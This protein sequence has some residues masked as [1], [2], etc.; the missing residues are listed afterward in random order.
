MPLAVIVIG[1]GATGLMAARELS[2]AG[3]EVTILE[4]AAQPGGRM[5]TILQ[6]GFT[7]PVEGGAEF[8][9][10]ELE[11]SLRL[12]KE[13]GIPLHPVRS[14]MTQVR[15]G[16]WT[17]NDT[18]TEGWDRL[19]K[20]MAAL[21]E[22]EPIARFL[23]TE[24]PEEKYTGLRNSVRGF[25]EGYDLADMDRA[26]TKALYK[27]WSHEGDD[28]EYRLEGGYRQLTSYLTGQ[29]LAGGCVLHL[30]TPVTHIHWQQGRVELTAATG[31]RFTG[32][33]LLITVPLGVLQ[34]EL[35]SSA[36][37]SPPGHP[38]G[39]S[40]PALQFFPPIPAHLQA[41]RQLGYGSVIKILLE[42][43]APFWNKKKKPGRTLFLLSDEKIPTWWTQA[44]DTG[45]LLTGWL[46]GENMRIFQGQ[47]TEQRMDACLSAVASIFSV[48]K[49][50]LQQQLTASLIL[51]WSTAPY[52]SGG[53]SFETVGSAEARAVLSQ[54]VSETLYFAGEALYEGNAPATV[55]AALCSGHIVAQKIIA[56]P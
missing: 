27:E 34:T 42:F 33:R 25:A 26:S 14:D 46:T 20:K 19:M 22:D 54:P 56:Q 55:E 5:H 2:A 52:I 41:A 10:G 32:D 24:F 7:G 50:F 38:S 4:A 1:A 31:H 15:K 48:D 47:N 36:T 18:M 37:P 28:E 11:W 17:H 53:Y 44:D 39:S 40:A 16:K 13:A 45:T 21:Q 9:H 6:P 30:S 49:S 51:D 8:I 35:P 12:A 23:A 3:F 29:C 43:K